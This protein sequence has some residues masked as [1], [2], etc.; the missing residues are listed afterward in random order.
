[1]LTAERSRARAAHR[2]ADLGAGTLAV[3]GAAASTVQIRRV[4]TSPCR[5]RT[6]RQRR[7]RRAATVLQAPLCGAIPA[8]VRAFI[9]VLCFLVGACRCERVTMASADISVASAQLDF[10]KVALGVSVPLTVEVRNS[11]V[12]SSPL[13]L[14]VSGPFALQGSTAGSI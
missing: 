8:Q 13:A 3:L 11:G 14:A 9:A 4:Q 5:G 1:G 7:R 2:F 10:G 12:A 6:R